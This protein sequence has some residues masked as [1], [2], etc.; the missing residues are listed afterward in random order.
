MPALIDAPCPCRNREVGVIHGGEGFD[1]VGQGIDAAIR[2]HL[3]RAGDSHERIDDGHSGPK[4]IAQ[5][6]HLDLVVRVG[7]HGSSGYFR[8]GPGRRRHTNQR[9]DRTRDLEFSDV[10][11]RVAAVS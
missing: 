10:I 4:I 1:G 6:S 8:A 11:S 9:Q 7:E 3:G 5:H 2:G